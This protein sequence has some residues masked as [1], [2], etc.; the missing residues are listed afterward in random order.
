MTYLVGFSPHKDD[1]CALDLACQL[2]RTES[3]TVDAVTV[4]PAGWTAVAG[5]SDRDFEQWA[6]EEGEASSKEALASLA[7]HPDVAGSAYW[8]SGRS[9]PAAL[10]AR[11]SE[12]GARCIVVGSGLG[13]TDGR[14]SVTSKAERLLHSSHIP[15]AVAPRG[16]EAGP[17]SRITR[18]TVGF[19]D[20]DASWTLLDEAATLA[21]RHGGILRIVTFAI[22]RRSLVTTSVSGAEGMVHQQTLRQARSWLD[23]AVEHLRD[24]GMTEPAVRAAVV[25]GNTWTEAIDS[26]G[27]AKGDLLT[28]GSSATHRLTNVFLGSSASKILRQSPVPVLVLP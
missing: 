23:Q 20:D 9:V 12:V 11:A 8:V 2:A 18:L 22:R 16:Y 1:D 10:L 25:E 7:R 15:V 21:R 6:A 19:R 26:V 4:V 13:G 14:V 28:I 27:W 3:D 17:Q 24:Q 5:D